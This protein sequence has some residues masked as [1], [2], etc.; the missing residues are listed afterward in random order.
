[1]R[2]RGIEWCLLL[3]GLAAIDVWLGSKATTALSQSWE[4]WVFDRQ[5]RDKPAPFR[6]YLADCARNFAGHARARLGLPAG[7][8]QA[9]VPAPD[10]A[11]EASR[12]GVAEHGLV[13]RLKIPR[14]HLSATVREG[15]DE[16]TL[17]LAL[18]HIP[19]TAFPGQP[20]N[21]GVAGHRDTLFRPLREIRKSD[22]IWFETT[23]G[24]Y[25]YQVESTE[26]V[27]PR[28]VS[29]LK[30]DRRQELTLVT[31]YP[32]DYVGAAPDRFIVKARQMAENT[33]AARAGNSVTLAALHS[34]SGPARAQHAGIARAGK[35]YAGRRTGNRQHQWMRVNG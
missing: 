28:D 31:C 1:M 7:S 16:G 34:R 18:G 10:V 4:N 32:F 9:A 3:V 21:V 25:R 26:I 35:R 27:Q 20:G 23:A 11:G 17:Q 15:T 8:E 19:A 13:G 5:L 6:A 12:R 24:S 14:L 30:P 22:I 2:R 33:S 29:V